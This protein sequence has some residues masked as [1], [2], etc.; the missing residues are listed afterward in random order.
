MVRGESEIVGQ[1]AIFD[2][3]VAAGR[4]VAFS[5]DPL[6]RFLNHHDFALV[7]NVLLNWN[8]R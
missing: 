3:P 2:I 4:V 5:F 1:G 8:D 6:H 7:W